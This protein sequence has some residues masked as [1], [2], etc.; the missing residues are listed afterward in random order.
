MKDKSLK[1]N[2]IL[3]GLKQCFGI[4]FPLITFPYVSRTLGEDGF[5]KYSFSWSIVS[6]FVLLAGLG[7]STYAI[8]EGARIRDDKEKLS[9]FCSEA[10]TINVITT[11]ISLCLLV[12]ISIVSTK[13]R[14]YFQNPATVRHFTG[15]Y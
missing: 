13:I 8:R 6:Y 9:Q 1:I 4:L 3:N 5:G 14:N 7:V 2:A 15:D 11:I 10:F 12:I